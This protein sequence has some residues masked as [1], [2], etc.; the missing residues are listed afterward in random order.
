M[1]EMEK[2]LLEA[3]VQMLGNLVA[4]EFAEMINSY[5]PRLRPMVIG[6]M[7]AFVAGVRATFTE[8]EIKI[9]DAIRESSKVVTLVRERQEEDE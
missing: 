2:K 3:G 7:E 4:L 1:D 9:A 8:N 6:Q 5:P